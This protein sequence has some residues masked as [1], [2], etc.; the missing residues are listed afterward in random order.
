LSRHKGVSFQSAATADFKVAKER[1]D[2]LAG[3]TKDTG[4]ND[5]KVKF[6]M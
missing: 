2:S 3:A 4:I 5:A 6:G 1:C